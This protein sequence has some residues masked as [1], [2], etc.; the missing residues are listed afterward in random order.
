MKILLIGD[1]HFKTNNVYEI[2]QFIQNI[3]K[4]VETKKYNKI[5]L[6]GDILDTHENKFKNTLQG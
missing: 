5:I 4:L 3:Y 2:D 6:L 1:P